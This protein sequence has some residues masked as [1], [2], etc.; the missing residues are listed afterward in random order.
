MKIIWDAM[1]D[2]RRDVKQIERDLPEVYVRKDDF[3]EGVREMRE[4]IKELRN[5]MKTSFQ[6]VDATLGT[7]FKRLE[8]KEDRDE[9]R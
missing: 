7:I 1:K 5:D 4:T 2:L 8:N 6:H 3:R 9:R